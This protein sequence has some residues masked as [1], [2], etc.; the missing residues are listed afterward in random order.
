[1]VGRG[2]LCGSV[3]CVVCVVCVRE[4]VSVCAGHVLENVQVYISVCL[5][6]TQ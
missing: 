1:M 5:H 2:G 4:S 6:T 3:V